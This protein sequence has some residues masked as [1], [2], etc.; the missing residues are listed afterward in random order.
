MRL[1]QNHAETRGLDPLA[2]QTHI[3]LGL[4]IDGGHKPEDYERQIVTQL[5]ESPAQ[6]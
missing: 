4:R 3:R 5:K 2:C 1:L 6:R